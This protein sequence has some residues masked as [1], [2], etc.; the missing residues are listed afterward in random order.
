MGQKR[1]YLAGGIGGLS[2]GEA[3]N[4]REAAIDKLKQYGITGISPM[5]AK[6]AL[7]DVKAI[8]VD[9]G[10]EY[11]DPT[12][13]FNGITHRDRWDT[14]RSHIIIMNLMDEERLS[15]GTCIEMGWADMTRTPVIIICQEGGMYDNH[16]MVNSIVGYK[17]RT[18]E[19][20]IEVARRIL[21]P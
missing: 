12:L 15:I 10:A 3:T 8:D 19:A 5:R 21:H 11:D 18:L 1:V 14:I 16:P 13:T 7:K 4:W 17:V 9:R 2:Y 6:E 20:A